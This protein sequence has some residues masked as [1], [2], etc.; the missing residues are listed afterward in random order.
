MNLRGPESMAATNGRAHRQ[1]VRRENETA[2][3]R[4]DKVY[5]WVRSY[6]IMRVSQFWNS[7]SLLTAANPTTL[8]FALS[9]PEARRRSYTRPRHFNRELDTVDSPLIRTF[10]GTDSRAG[11]TDSALLLVEKG[12]AIYCWRF[13]RGCQSPLGPPAAYLPSAVADATKTSSEPSTHD[14]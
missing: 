1:T 10:R 6:I 11:A 7:R 8:F 12:G 14:G 13:F 4:L 5:V 9:H 3:R 2:A